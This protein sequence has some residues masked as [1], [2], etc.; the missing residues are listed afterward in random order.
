MR[1]DLGQGDFSTL[2]KTFFP[3][4]WRSKGGNSCSQWFGL[5]GARSIEEF[6]GNL[7]PLC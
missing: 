1:L 7:Y 2:L 6:L 4:S 5:E 3:L